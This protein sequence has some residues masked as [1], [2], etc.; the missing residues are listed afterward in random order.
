MDLCE[1]DATEQAALVRR[2]EVSPLELV[3]A[4]IGRIEA[5]NPEINAVIHPLFDRARAVAAA[6]PGDGPFHGVPIVVKDFDGMLADAPYCAGNHTLSDKGWVAPSSCWLF[7]RLEQAGFVIVG[8]TNTPE[9]GL[10]PTTEPLA[11]GPTANPWNRAHSAGGSSGGTAAAVAAGMVALGH[12]GDGGGSL[13]VPASMCGLFGL[14]PSRGRVSLG[15]DE[16]ESWAGLVARHVISRSVRDSAAV[17][18]LLSG[19]ETGDWYHAPPPARPYAEELGE[20][21]GQ[22]RIG[23]R[24][25]APLGLTVT[26]PECVAATRTAAGVL[27]ASGH[28]VEEASPDG[29]NDLDA[30]EA[31]STIMLV[32][33]EADLG[34]LADMIGRPITADDVEP[35]TW[36]LH[37]GAVTVDGASYVRALG[38]LHR[39]ARRVIAWWADTGFDV[40]LTPTCAEPPPLLGDIGNQTDGGI[41]ASARSVPFAIYTVPFNATGQPAMSVPMTHDPAGLPLGVQ[42]VAAPNRE[43]IL[44]RVAAQLEQL[45]PWP[46]LPPALDS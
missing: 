10:M 35:M 36:M 39:W 16:A 41:Q 24:T 46:T 38:R 27:E 42:L 26:D 4:A 13:R 3:D 33:L 5:L 40:L 14:K 30:L 25:E 21:P 17:L 6:G 37:E 43:D 29:L 44:F 34:D 45:R 20:L 12:G 18:D 9:F 28:V 19:Y 7:D 23:I 32:S 31:I 2:G 22:L 15:P 8:K 11:F 1:L